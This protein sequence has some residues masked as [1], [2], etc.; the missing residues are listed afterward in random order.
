[1]PDPSYDT[2]ESFSWTGAQPLR[3][4][5]ERAG[6]RVLTAENRRLIIDQAIAV[7]D[8]FYV[9]LPQKRA[10]HGANPVQRLKE[11]RRN[12]SHTHTD[13]DFFGELCDSFVI[14]R[15]LHTAFALPTIYQKHAA[16]LPF[17]VEACAEEGAEGGKGAYRYIVTKVQEGFEP[18]VTPGSAPFVPGVEVLEWSGVPI[19]RA[20]QIAALRS[21]GTSPEARHGRGVQFLTTR[22]MQ[23][24]PP[25]DEAWVE[26]SY[27]AEGEKTGTLRCEWRVI[28]VQ[29]APATAARPDPAS[30]LGHGLDQEAYTLGR[31]RVQVHAPRVIAAEQR[32]AQG[33]CP[34]PLADD[35]VATP[36]PGKFQA[37]RVHDGRFGYIRLHSFATDHPQEYLK[38]FVKVLAELPRE[39]LILDVRCN[40]GG[41]ISLAESLLQLLT[42]RRIQPAPA[43]LIATP[44]VL[45]LCEAMED[46]KPWAASVRYA[47]ETGAGYSDPHPMTP[48]EDC[49][50]IG[51]RYHGPVVL[52]TDALCYSAT[53]IFAAGFQDHEIGP[54]L[55]CDATTGAGGANVIQHDLLRKKLGDDGAL[56]QKLPHGCGLRFAIRRTLRVGGKAGAVLEE[57]GVRPDLQPLHHITRDDLLD[58]NRDLIARAA[59]ELAGLPWH[60]LDAAVA[61]GRLVVKTRGIGRV[62]I[63]LDDCPLPSLAVEGDTRELSERA[64]E[65]PQGKPWTVLELKGF[66]DGKQVAARRL[67]PRPGFGG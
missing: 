1:M 59:G 4:F 27:R 45:T 40:S 28:E 31:A 37:R 36:L 55:G 67:R 48:P 7:L 11:V 66:T 61:R 23:R 52:V 26:L 50:G 47:I 3:D 12:L 29:A 39:G 56:L 2:L 64:S 14:L 38:A 34:G 9:H 46:L 30:G 49:N 22:P 63:Y 41:R 5:V 44:E 65:L 15:D 18:Q 32:R 20:V 25:P 17:L 13:Q 24:Q 35:E 8:S 62:D 10:V 54:I 58:R 57:A 33:Q 6:T 43:Q 16:V 42:W 19:R 51:Q 21:A 60:A 53:D